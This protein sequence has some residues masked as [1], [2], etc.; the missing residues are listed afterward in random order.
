[1][2]TQALIRRTAARLAPL[3]AVLDRGAGGAFGL[4]GDERAHRWEAGAQDAETEFDDGPDF[5]AGVG[6]LGGDG[7]S[8]RWGGLGWGWGIRT[9]WVGAGEFVG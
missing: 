3:F 8:F 9:T 1:M 6:P 4:S 2:L 7:V 5:G